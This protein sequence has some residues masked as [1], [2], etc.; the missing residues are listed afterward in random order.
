[1][2]KREIDRSIDRSWPNEVDKRS[3]WENG[4]GEQNLIHPSQQLTLILLILLLLLLQLT[5]LPLLLLLMS[6]LNSL[7]VRENLEEEVLTT[8][9]ILTATRVKS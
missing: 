2:G 9:L 1:M 3:C 7:L 8:K 5:L 4:L 6:Q